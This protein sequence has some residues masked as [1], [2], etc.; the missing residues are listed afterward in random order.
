MYTFA[1][2]H[3]AAQEPA[4]AWRSGKSLHKRGAAPEPAQEWRAKIIVTE[5]AEQGDPN[6]AH[7][8]PWKQH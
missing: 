6:S 5:Q 2:K 4:R 8:Q 7:R 3:G 1:T